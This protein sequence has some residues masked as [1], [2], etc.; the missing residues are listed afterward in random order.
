MGTRVHLIVVGVDGPAA[1]ALLDAAV[2]RI[3]DLERRWSRFVPASELCRLNAAAGAM[4]I[5]E[6][7]TYALVERAVAAWEATAGR[8]DPTV[9]DA[10]VAAGYDRTFAEVADVAEAAE[11]AE[12]ATHHRPTSA[13]APVPGCGDIGLDPV[14]HAVTLPPG[15]H[16]DLGG[17]GKGW[18]ADLV[19]DQ[20]LAA[21]ASGACANLGGDLR[22]AGEAP[23]PDGWTVAVEDPLAPERTLATVALLHGAV[24]TTTR[25]R[26]RWAAPE[27]ER[28]HLIDP[29]TGRPAATGLSSVTVVAADATTAE[30]V[31]KA[32]FVAG[33]ADGRGLVE[34]AGAAAL[35]VDDDGTPHPAG[36]IEEYLR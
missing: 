4:V 28:H 26:R 33:L 34:A 23:T 29:A 22:V 13:I 16:L 14:L 5:L 35:L 31:A 12:A 2:D 6:P 19:V 17:I 10:L 1:E 30:V 36:P 24:A 20:L 25:T 11:A 3:D 8:F 9:H 21:G 27:G 15:V 32:A 7:D 18:T